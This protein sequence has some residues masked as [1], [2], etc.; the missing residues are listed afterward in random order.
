MGDYDLANMVS[1]L[2][3]DQGV[4]WINSSS[5]LYSSSS[6]SS[7]SNISMSCSSVV[8][9]FRH[10]LV[11][12]ALLSNSANALFNRFTLLEIS[13]LLLCL[14]GQHYERWRVFQWW[15]EAQGSRAVHC[16]STV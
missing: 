13:G 2:F 15:G 12:C 3:G 10:V 16:N 1:P 5:V 11:F 4:P 6:A 14:L 7:S 9:D 8:E